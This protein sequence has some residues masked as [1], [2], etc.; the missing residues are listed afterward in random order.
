MSASNTLW[1]A[2]SKLRLA[3]LADLELLQQWDEQAHVIA[4]D[5]NSD[6]GWEGELGRKPDWR[7]QLIA[8]LDSRPIGFIQIIDPERE[9]SHYWGDVAANLR[10]IDL[11]IGSETDL[12]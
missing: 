8:E 11:W 9:E 12:R 4:S 2:S 10:A 5:P 6:W 3:T 7:Q 1:K